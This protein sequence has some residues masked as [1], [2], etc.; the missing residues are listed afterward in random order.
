MMKVFVFAL[1]L[2]LSVGAFATPKATRKIPPEFPPEAV[3]KNINSGEVKAKLTI[4]ADGKVTNVEILDANPKRVFDKATIAALMEW[5]FDTGGKEDTA[6]IKL[7][8]RNDE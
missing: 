7:V 6:E 2:V 4:A 1:A 3:R 5:R 8:F